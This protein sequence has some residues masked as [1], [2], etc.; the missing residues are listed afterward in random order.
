[1]QILLL[2]AGKSSYFLIQYLLNSK[3]ELDLK[4]TICD[5]N[6]ANIAKEFPVDAY[7]FVSIDINNDSERQALIK[8]KTLVISMLPAFMHPLVAKDCLVCGVHFASA[9]YQSAELKALAADIKQKGLIFL[10]ECGLDPGIDH[11]S[12]MEEI[13]Q[14]QGD[15]GTITSFRSYCGGLIAPAYND[16]PWGYK[17]SWNP[18]NVVLAG[19]GTAQYIENGKMKFLPYHRLFEKTEQIELHNGQ[20]FEGYPNR[21]SIAYQSVYGLENVKSLIRGTLRMPMFCKAWN[22]LI[23]LGLTED[24]YKVKLNNEMTLAEF[25]ACFVDEKQ[26]VSLEQAFIKQFDLLNEEAIFSMIKWLGLFESKA[27]NLK[28]EASP[29]Q[30]LQTVLEEKWKLQAQDR[31]LVVMQHVFEFQMEGKAYVRKADLYLEGESAVKTAM[32]KTVGLPLAIAAK[33]ILEKKV[34]RLGLILPVYKE[35]YKP[36]LS[37]LDKHGINF[38]IQNL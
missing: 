35:I 21:D 31:D 22:V 36:I 30:I 19:Q 3:I 5:L 37:E 25:T 17:F 18:R 28:S 16:N 11:M 13:H 12:A 27:L 23:N 2:G 7:E 20:R 6:Q 14:I 10:N 32:A 4:L 8:D 24:H 26:G 15:G 29:A 33:M 9:S 38:K 34:N 1:M